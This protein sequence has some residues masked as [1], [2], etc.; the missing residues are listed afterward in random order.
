[1]GRRVAALCALL[2]VACPVDVAAQRAQPTAQ[3][4]ETAA[5]VLA[6]YE[7]AMDRAKVPDVV[8]FESAVEQVGPRNIAQTHRVYRSGLTERDELLAAD[9]L[10]LATPEIRII[11][12][13]VNRYNVTTLA[14]RAKDYAFSLLG[15]QSDGAHTDYVFATSARAPAAF[16][17]DSVTIDGLVH[18]PRSIAYTVSAGGVRG[19]GTLTFTKA[20]KYWVIEEASATA[21]I[22]GKVARE[23]IVFSRYDFPRSLP[24]ST[25]IEPRAGPAPGP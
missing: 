9:G 13:R 11:R 14:P 8:R 15:E 23:R 12:D 17:V 20:D 21:R 10:A 22:A 18:L 1:M 5:T 3:P 16:T 2:A 7:A 4:L 19:H 6:K 24:D 25:F